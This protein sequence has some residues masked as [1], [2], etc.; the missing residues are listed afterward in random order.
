MEWNKKDL[1]KWDI[2][3]YHQFIKIMERFIRFTLP[4]IIKNT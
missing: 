4:N 2:L 1:Q 3:G